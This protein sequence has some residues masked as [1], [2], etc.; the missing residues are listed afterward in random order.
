[1]TYWV[2]R[3]VTSFECILYTRICCIMLCSETAFTCICDVSFLF[4]PN[5]A[6]RGTSLRWL[7]F[8][9][10]LPVVISASISHIKF[11]L[12]WVINWYLLQECTW[13]WWLTSTLRPYLLTAFNYIHEKNKQSKTP[14]SHISGIEV[15]GACVF[16]EGILV[17]IN[18]R[19]L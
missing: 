19:H 12:T 8:L 2:K 11:S 15:S 17:Q 9:N 5:V 14:V 16:A 10:N 18:W 13:C 1:M 3:G 4:G 7:L 6:L